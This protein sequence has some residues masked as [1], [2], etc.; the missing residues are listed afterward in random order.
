[1]F[2]MGGKIGV[3]VKAACDAPNDNIKEAMKN[4]AMQIAAMNPQFVKD[5][6]MTA[7][8]MAKEKDTIVDSSLNDTASLPKPILSSTSFQMKLRLFLQDLLWIIRLLTLR[9]RSSQVLLT[10]V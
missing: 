8:F 5:E 2:H 10:D 7:D 3:L 9:T 6:D 1:M 4:V